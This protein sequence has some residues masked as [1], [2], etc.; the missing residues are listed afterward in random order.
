MPARANRSSSSSDIYSG[1]GNSGVGLAGTDGSGHANEQTSEA[2]PGGAVSLS[3]AAGGSVR[4]ATGGAALLG[5]LSN[6]IG[7]RPWITTEHSTTRQQ[8]VSKSWLPGTFWKTGRSI[9]RSELSP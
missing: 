4:A 8:I 3:M 1:S 9:S 6:T 5:F 2:G 7:E